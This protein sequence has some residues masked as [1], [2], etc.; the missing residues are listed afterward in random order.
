MLNRLL[1]TTFVLL[2]LMAS[3]SKD[4]SQE[5]AN[6]VISDVQRTPLSAME[7][8]NKIDESLQTKGSFNW[9]DAST[10]LLWSASVHGQNIVT[11]GFGNNSEDF[12]RTKSANNANIQKQLLSII[13]KYE[14]QA[15]SE[16]LINA[17]SYLN[18][19]DVVIKKQETLIALRQSKFIRYI[20]PVILSILP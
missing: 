4:E 6:M 1:K 10:H 18:L 13:Q 12:D 2:F 3:C 14:G 5:D 15:L 7:V 19:M 20:E 9:K 17:D 16:I 11:I 8:K